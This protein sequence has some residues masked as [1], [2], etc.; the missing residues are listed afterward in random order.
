MITPRKQNSM[1]DIDLDVD[2]SDEYIIYPLLPRRKGSI[3][4]GGASEGGKTTLALG[5]ASSITDGLPVLGFPSYRA[6]VDYV[7][8]AHSKELVESIAKRANVTN[9][10]IHDFDIDRA[11]NGSGTG[12]SL[13]ESICI[14]AKQRNPEVEV[15]FIEG[16]QS[17]LISGSIN[18][19]G[20]VAKLMREIENTQ[21][22]YSVAFVSMDRS[23]KPSDRTRSIRAI[24]RF[25]G[26]QAWTQRAT[27]FLSID[28]MNPSCPT[29]PFREISIVSSLCANSTQPWKFTDDGRLIPAPEALADANYFNQRWQQFEGLLAE[30]EG[31]EMT[32]GELFELADLF[33][34]SVSALQNH[35]GGL[36]SAGR[37]ERVG[38]GKYRI[39]RKQ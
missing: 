17:L 7:T 13:F 35:L 9:V 12:K 6:C 1:P 22:K 31:Q 5:M 19:H 3:I 27:A 25:M 29:D 30:Y 33:S 28:H 37:L 2:H 8:I 26:N 16:L 4:I 10:A 18:H 34:I 11:T 38:H 39:C 24:E 36:K 15:L 14:G 23:A 21:E 32:F 20:P